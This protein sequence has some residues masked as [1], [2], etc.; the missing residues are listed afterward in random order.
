MCNFKGVNPLNKL[1]EVDYLMKKILLS[2]VFVL[3]AI[4][5]SII[6]TY[7]HLQIPTEQDVLNM[8]T[9]RSVAAEEVYVIKEIGQQWLTIYGNSQSITIAELKQNWLGTWKLSE[10]GA[11][12]S[13]YYPP[14]E[15]DQ[16]IWSASGKSNENAS[17][18]FGEVIDPEIVKITVETQ[19]GIFENVPFIESIG[20]RFFLKRAEGLIL[21][22]VNISGFSQSDEL[23]YSSKSP[24]NKE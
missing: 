20:H 14:L 4:L 8:T 24:I 19:N 1:K 22:P 3:T 5:C 12:S 6:I 16:I 2:F 13:M 9:S 21:M 10:E 7:K 23:I 17:Y 11:L 15:D 18:Y